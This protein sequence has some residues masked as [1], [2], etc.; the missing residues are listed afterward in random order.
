MK[1][2][3]KGG[4]PKSTLVVSAEDRK[5]LKRVVR[6]ATSAQRD[7]LRAQGV[8]LSLQGAANKAISEQLGVCAHAVGKWRERFVQHGVA[9]LLD[10]PRSKDSLR[11][12]DKVVTAIVRATLEKTPKGATHWR[13][14]L[15]AKHAGVSHRLQDLASFSIE[16]PSTNDILTQHG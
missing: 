6:A 2:R 10:A 7:V 9:G 3:N 14:R 16:T 4:R 11:V 13:T 12:P 1:E 8:L 5:E 15:M